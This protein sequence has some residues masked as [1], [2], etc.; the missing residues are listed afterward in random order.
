MAKEVN[1]KGGGGGWLLLR[2][3]LYITRNKYLNN[4]FCS[5]NKSSMPRLLYEER[6]M[7]VIIISLEG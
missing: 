3:S 6:A 4:Q 2:N 7:S 1:R 5:N